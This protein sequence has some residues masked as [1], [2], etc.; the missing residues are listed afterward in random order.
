VAVVAGVILLQVVPA[1]D[2]P[3][4]DEALAESALALGDE[5]AEL[6]VDEVVPVAAGE[7]PEGAKGVELLA[8]GALVVKLAGSARALRQVVDAIRDWVGRTDGRTVR[9][10]VD[11]DVLEVTGA[12]STDVKQLIDAWV[13]RHGDA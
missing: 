7:I 12:S 9:M 8:L 5:L 1:G 13:Q 4:D 6:D 2:A 3:D 10:A 11:G